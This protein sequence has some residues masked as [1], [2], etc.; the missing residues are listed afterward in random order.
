M[1]KTVTEKKDREETV[2]QRKNWSGRERWK[3]WTGTERSRQ[4]G[5]RCAQLAQ[6]IIS[7]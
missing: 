6:V 3:A 1:A 7:R 4:R 2:T 5:Q